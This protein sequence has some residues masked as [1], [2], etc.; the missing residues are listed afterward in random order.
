MGLGNAVIGAL[1]QVVD[2]LLSLYVWIIIARAIISWVNPSPYH[3]V[4]RFLYRVT[5][6]VLRPIRRII[7]PIY[8]IDFSPVIVIFVIYLIKNILYRMFVYSLF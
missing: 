4:V 2:L 3:P 1:V 6:P 8:G 5:E 7:P